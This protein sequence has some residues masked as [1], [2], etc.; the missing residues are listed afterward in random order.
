MF[1]AFSDEVAL[2]L[3]FNQS[4]DRAIR[5]NIQMMRI[6][7]RMREILITHKDILLK[8]EQIEKQVMHHDEEI[9]MIFT[10][11][12][13]LLNPPPQPGKPIGFKVSKGK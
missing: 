10:A 12:E 3:T 13:E 5:V 9:Q 7:T 4:G 6:F 2:R 8:I 1:A 11:L